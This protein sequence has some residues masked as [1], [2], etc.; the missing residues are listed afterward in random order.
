M[1]IIILSLLIL[2]LTQCGPK[3]ISKSEANEK[4]KRRC[5][6]RAEKASASLAARSAFELREAC[7]FSEEQVLQMFTE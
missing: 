6:A 7:G 3:S 5:L 2:L 1:R 4:T